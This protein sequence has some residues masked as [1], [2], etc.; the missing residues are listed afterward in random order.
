[1]RLAVCAHFLH[2][3]HGSSGRLRGVKLTCMAQV[4]AIKQNKPLMVVGTPGRL[5]ELSRSGALQTHPAGILVLDEVCTP[6]LLECAHCDL[7]GN[8]NGSPGSHL[9]WCM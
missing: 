9:A 8:H 2:T 6:S 5:A 7:I 4:E 3:K 1:M